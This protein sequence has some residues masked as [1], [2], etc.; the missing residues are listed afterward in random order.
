MY[1][2]ICIHIYT[3]IFICIHIL[4]STY[5]F[6]SICVYLYVY[7]YKYTYGYMYIHIHI[8]IYIF[9]CIYV[10]VYVYIH[11]YESL[12][13]NVT[14]SHANWLLYNTWSDFFTPNMTHVYMTS[15]SHAWVSPCRRMYVLVLA[16][17]NSTGWRKPIGCPNLQVI[18][19]KEPLIIGLFCGNDLSWWGIL[20]SFATLYHKTS[21]T[22]LSHIKRI[23]KSLSHARAKYRSSWQIISVTWYFTHMNMSWHTYSQVMSCV[24]A[25]TFAVDE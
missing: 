5:A 17:R 3:Y 20:W 13:R 8:Y 21:H 15:M 24:R 12:S 23:S 6:I 11:I 9:I 2:Y 1:I 14:Y 4:I 18:F 25:S 22:W 16:N 7:L 10:F 19:R